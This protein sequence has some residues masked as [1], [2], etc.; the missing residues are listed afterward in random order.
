MSFTVDST[1]VKQDF[2]EFMTSNNDSRPGYP[3]FIY[4]QIDALE[5]GN[6]MLTV[7]IDSIQGNISAMIDYLTYTPSFANLL[8]KPDF[9]HPTPT[10][11]NE[12][13]PSGSTT[14][15]TNNVVQRGT[16]SQNKGAIIGAVIGSVALVALAFWWLL[17]RRR[18]IRR[19]R[20]YLEDKILIDSD[21]SFKFQGIR[22]FRD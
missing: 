18:N 8:E 9:S 10:S 1:T 7:S 17:Q 21:G 2:T 15:T 12:L 13:L 6:H 5:A 3:H 4:F 14:S 11:T 22:T 16:H 19:R 20:V